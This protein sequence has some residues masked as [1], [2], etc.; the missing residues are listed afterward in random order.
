[1]IISE[2]SSVTGSRIKLNNLYDSVI[3]AG[4]K[5][6]LD[7]VSNTQQVITLKSSN[8]DLKQKF[9]LNCWKINLINERGKSN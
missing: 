3:V 5:K 6:E 4:S 8:L 7:L 9:S 1:M 2:N